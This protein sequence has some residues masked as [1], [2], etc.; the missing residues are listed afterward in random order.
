MDFIKI[1]VAYFNKVSQW[2]KHEI[3]TSVEKFWHTQVLD[4]K[5][6][7]LEKVSAF[8][9]TLWWLKAVE[10]AFIFSFIYLFNSF[11]FFFWF[12]FSFFVVLYGVPKL[13][14]LH[15][16]THLFIYLILCSYIL[17]IILVSFFVYH[18]FTFLQGKSS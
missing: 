2:T 11:F 8:R 4:L 18:H 7:W 16:L 15:L 13:S 3:V 10:F 14:N 12:Y 6:F 9:G 17:L 5:Y 1:S